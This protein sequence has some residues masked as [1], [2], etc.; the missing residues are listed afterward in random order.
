ML[1]WAGGTAGLR[2]YIRQ[3]IGGDA[4]YDPLGSALALLLW[5][6]ITGL[7]ILI[8]GELNAATSLDSTAFYARVLKGDIEKQVN[9]WLGKVKPDPNS[10]PAPPIDKEP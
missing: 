1:V 5:L 7:A 2:F 4:A 6:W 9:E 10:E 8:G 3:T